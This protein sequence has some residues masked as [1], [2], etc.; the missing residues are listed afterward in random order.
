[1]PRLLRLGHVSRAGPW[2]GTVP[3]AQSPPKAQRAGPRPEIGPRQPLQPRTVWRNIDHVTSNRYFAC[4]IRYRGHRMSCDCFKRC[5]R[6]PKRRWRWS[7]WRSSRWCLSRWRLPWCSRTPWSG[8]RRRSC[9]RRCCCA[10]LRILPLSTL[11]LGFRDPPHGPGQL[12]GQVSRRPDPPEW[13]R[14]R[15][16]QGVA[17][18]VALTGPA[19]F[20]QAAS[21][22]LRS[23][24]VAVQETAA[25]PVFCRGCSSARRWHSWPWIADR[26]RGACHRAALCADP[27]A[28]LSGTTWIDCPRTD[29]R[30]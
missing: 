7:R 18:Y 13:P 2:S 23:R 3:S 26:V 6:I 27:L 11:L 4:C 9:C 19:I 5:L 21:A 12:A 29:D 22:P 30:R 20:T 24:R 15:D 16:R 14:H 10:T 17:G 8:D 25:E 28:H 1:M